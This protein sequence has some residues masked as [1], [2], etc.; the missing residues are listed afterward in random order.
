MPEGSVVYDQYVDRASDST[1]VNVGLSMLKAFF[2]GL[3]SPVA[4][5]VPTNVYRNCQC[6]FSAEV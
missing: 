5:Y 2:L 6:T 1:I 4:A 3:L